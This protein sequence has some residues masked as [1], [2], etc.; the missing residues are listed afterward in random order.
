M[1]ADE[2][3]R[4]DAERNRRLVIETGVEL[5][6]DDPDSSMQDVA[7]ASGIGRTTI[8]RHFPNRES[9]LEAVTAAIVATAREEITAAVADPD[10][11]RAIRSLGAA[12][13][14]L[15]LRYGRLFATRDG[16]SATY[17]AFKE[18]ETS[19]ARRF[20]ASARERGAIR[21]DMPIDWL[22]SIIQAV[23]FT[24]IDEIDAEA[25]GT[26]EAVQLAGDTLVAIL[27]PR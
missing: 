11:E 20:L 13:I 3:R 12:S 16:E 19:P 23:T 10:P 2:Q 14:D 4:R 22:R 5:L 9:L 15:A 18:D 27:L 6:S 24:A 1:P 25:A 7:D 17:E 26:E 21:A 8:Y